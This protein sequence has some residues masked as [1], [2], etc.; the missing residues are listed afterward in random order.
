MLDPTALL[1]RSLRQRLRRLEA[2]FTWSFALACHVL[3]DSFVQSLAFG[4]GLGK[5]FVP[6]FAF[7]YR[8]R[9]TVLQEAKLGSTSLPTTS[10]VGVSSLHIH[11]LLGPH[12]HPKRL[13]EPHE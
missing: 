11:P 8:V 6:S 9:Q 7:R 4:K 3:L 2:L 10:S 13:L 5:F 1:C 12:S